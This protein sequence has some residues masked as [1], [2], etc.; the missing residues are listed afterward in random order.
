MTFSKE[1]LLKLVILYCE[2]RAIF[3]GM[4]DVAIVC[5]LTI[6]LTMKW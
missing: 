6:I 1:L 5:G 2:F 3:M 4:T